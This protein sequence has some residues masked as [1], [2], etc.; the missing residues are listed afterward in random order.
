MEKYKNSIEIG[1]NIASISDIKK[2]TQGKDFCY[3]NIAQNSR[4]G[5]AVSKSHK[6]DFDKFL[7]QFQEDGYQKGDY[8]HIIGKLQTYQKENKTAFQ[9]RPY[10]IVKFE[11]SNTKENSNTE[12]EVDM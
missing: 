2:N 6:N 1:G 9:L 7:K 5:I 8:F 3:V 11:K 12:K 10:E 4:T